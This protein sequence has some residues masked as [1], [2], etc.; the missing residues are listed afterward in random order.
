MIVGVLSDI[1]DNL[2][3]LKKAIDIFKSH[4]AEEVIFCGD[5]CSPIP[6]RFLSS[7]FPGQV[8]CVF[9]NGDG[10]RFA[11]KEFAVSG[12]SNLVLH[13]EYAEVEIGSRKIAATHFPFYARA[14]A[15]KNT[16]D[17]VFYGHSHV[18]R[19]EQIGSTLCAN[20]GEIMGFKGTAS[21]GV[22]D[23]KTNMIEIITF[24]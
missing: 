5:F 20:P 2:D 1:H 6:A 16:Y 9:G 3:N 11:I 4:G 13:G 7:N 14:L 21:C 12:S 24:N 8:H 23:S 19:V 10:D 22:Y 18:S 17:A 15:E